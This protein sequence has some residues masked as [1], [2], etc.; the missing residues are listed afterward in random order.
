[1]NALASLGLGLLPVALET[2]AE[3]LISRDANATGA[4]DLFGNVLQAIAPVVPDL[5]HGDPGQLDKSPVTLKIAR[6]IE[7]ITHAYRVQV[8]DVTT[9]PQG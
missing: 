5:I 2:L 7:E 6:R 8:G 1:M 9:G 3:K 4:D